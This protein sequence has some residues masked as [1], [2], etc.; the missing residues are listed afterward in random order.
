MLGFAQRTKVSEAFPCVGARI[1]L[2]RSRR[3]WPGVR[4]VTK[5]G[6]AVR[7]IRMPRSTWWGQGVIPGFIPRP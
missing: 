5:Q 3:R 1:K 4:P 2:S 6:R 7:E